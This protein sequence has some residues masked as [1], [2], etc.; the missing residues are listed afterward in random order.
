VAFGQAAEPG[1]TAGSAKEQS[2]LA[3]VPELDLEGLRKTLARNPASARPLLVNLWA[4]WCEPCRE[5]F[6]DLVKLASEFGPRGL[7]FAAI[8]FD[9]AEDANTEI[10]KFLATVNA[11]TLPVYWLNVPDSEEAL[12]AVDPDA[13]GAL[14]ATFIFDR[15]GKVVYKH[16][17]RFDPKE[18]RQAIEGQFPAK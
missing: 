1:K 2:K 17:G 4:T 13:Q 18:L 15:N 9:F 8:S 6:P 11:G 14:P 5:E 10:P 16:T 7:E 3:K 12:K